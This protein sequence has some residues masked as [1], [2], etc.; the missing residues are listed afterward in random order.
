MGIDPSENQVLV[1]AENEK[2]ANVEFQVGAAEALPF[3]DNSV[4]LGLNL[5]TIFFFNGLKVVFFVVRH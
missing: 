3:P 5:M 2:A 1:A 4:N